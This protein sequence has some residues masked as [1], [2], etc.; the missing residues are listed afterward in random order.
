MTRST[1]LAPRRFFFSYEACASLAAPGAREHALQAQ[2]SYK[3]ARVM[4]SIFNLELR[5]AWPRIQYPLYHKLDADGNPVRYNSY[6]AKARAYYE[7]ISIPWVG[8]YAEFVRSSRRR[9]RITPICFPSNAHERTFGR[10][11]TQCSRGSNTCCVVS[12]CAQWN[13]LMA[14]ANRRG[15]NTSV[16]YVTP[17][18]AVR[19]REVSNWTAAL[20]EVANGWLD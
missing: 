11:A 9:T 3:S 14:E 5:V 16:T 17:S 12:W 10:A 4:D 13:D 1:T 8:I 20:E 19:A 7:N 2:A 15:F 18:L 6:D